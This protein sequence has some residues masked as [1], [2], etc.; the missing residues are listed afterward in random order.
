MLPYIKLFTDLSGTV[1]LLTDQEA[2][3]LFKGLL[4]YANGQGD[5]L[6]GQEKLIFS[7]LKAQIVRDE[8]NYNRDRENGNKG[9][10]PK[11]P[12]VSTEKPGV[13]DE[14]PGVISTKPG[15]SANNQD[16]EEEKEKEK[17]KDKDE[18]EEKEDTRPRVRES[19][20]GE[21]E[22]DP[23]IVTVQRELNGMA[24]SHYD[25]LEDFRKQLPDEMIT[26]AVNEAVANG[27]RNW[28]YVR[29]ILDR[30][31]RD[32]IRTVGE[33]RAETVKKRSTDR[34]QKIVNAQRY[35]QRQYTEEQLDEL[36][37][38]DREILRR[39]EEAGGCA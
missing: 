38:G 33:A 27:S 23:V 6:P 37:D 10:R 2:G 21:V 30:Y 32:G 3:R 14:K 8:E 11:K 7:M 36:S 13:S 16:K 26:E 9:G 5:E 29:K 28:A 39:L 15:V 18:E 34:G 35:E 12:G 31:I 24:Y 20:V 17:D 4:H 1:D 22:I 25:E 19:V